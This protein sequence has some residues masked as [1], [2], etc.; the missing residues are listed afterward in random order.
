M[1]RRKHRRSQ[2]SPRKKKPQ[3]RGRRQKRPFRL[4]T[5]AISIAISTIGLFSSATAFWSDVHVYSTDHL[6][7]NDIFSAPFLVKNNGLFTV[8]QV[9]AGCHIH[10]V[11]I[12]EQPFMSDVLITVGRARTLARGQSFSTS[13][14]NKLS[15]F[16]GADQTGRV[17]IRVS[18]RPM[19]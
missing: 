15:D 17:S 1:A 9:R 13:C 10:K 19:L 7:S 14:P 4:V 16:Q 11:S 8:Y 12:K 3:S 5:K 18:Y 6:D 2:R